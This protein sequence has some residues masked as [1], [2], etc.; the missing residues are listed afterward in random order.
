MIMVDDAVW[1]YKGSLYCHMMSDKKGQAGLDELHAFASALGLKRAWFQDR[2]GYPHYDLSQNM[3]RLAIR[4]GAQ[5][6]TGTEL[7]R[8]CKQGSNEHE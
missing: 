1:P 5:A 3:R 2:R 6:V 7:I 4:K 8:R